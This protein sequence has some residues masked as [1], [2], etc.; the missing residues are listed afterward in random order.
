MTS[1]ES[2][3]ILS[4]KTSEINSKLQKDIFTLTKDTNSRC[5]KQKNIGN[6]FDKTTFIQYDIF[7]QDENE[8]D[9]LLDF[10]KILGIS[11]YDPK[12]TD[13]QFQNRDRLID[14]GIDDDIL[15]RRKD[16]IEKNEKQENNQNYH[17]KMVVDNLSYR[18]ERHGCIAPSKDIVKKLTNKNFKNNKKEYNYYDVINTEEKFI[19]EN[20][21]QEKNEKNNEDLDKD[22]DEN[23]THEQNFYDLNDPFIDDGLIDEDD[24]SHNNNILFKLTLKPGNYTEQEILNNYYRN[25]KENENKIFKTKKVKNREEPKR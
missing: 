11:N 19:K 23:S 5:N 20:E 2:K 22:D 25:E 9:F 10:S 16:I 13:W 21:I 7:P 18:L 4:E 6:V 1:L 8:I 3:K 14:I 12:I 15:R 24:A 17:M